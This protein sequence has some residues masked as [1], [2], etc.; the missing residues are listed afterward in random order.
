MV[1]TRSIDSTDTQLGRHTLRLHSRIQPLVE[2]Y[3]RNHV[4]AMHCP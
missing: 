4:G 1:S 3:V 2:H